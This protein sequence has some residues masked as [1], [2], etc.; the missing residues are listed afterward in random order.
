MIGSPAMLSARRSPTPSP[1]PSPVLRR[2]RSAASRVTSA[3]N[4]DSVSHTGSTGHSRFEH[5]PAD[6]PAQVAAGERV[7]R[8]MQFSFMDPIEKWRARK[9]VPFKLILQVVKVVLITIQL[10]LFATCRL[11]H[12]SYLE[13]TQ[14]SLDHLFILG[15]DVMRE[16]NAYP[17]GGGPLAVYSQRRFFETLDFA[18]NEYY[19]LDSLAVSGIG[20]TDDTVPPVQLCLHEYRNARVFPVNMSYAF[21]SH[22]RQR[23]MELRPTPNE[24]QNH[25]FSTRAFLR[26]HAFNVSFVGLTR[27]TL[28]FALNAVRLKESMPADQPDCYRLNVALVLENGDQDGRMLV[29]MD[30]K[31]HMRTCNGDLQSDAAGTSLKA[32]FT[33]ISSLVIIVCLSSFAMCLRSIYRAQLLRIE[34]ASLLR[35]HFQYHMTYEEHFR[36]LNLW[37][38]IIIINDGLIVFASL[39]H[40]QLDIDLLASPVG[41]ETW[42]LCAVVLGAGNLLVWIGMLRY[43]SF[44]KSY[45]VLILTVKSAMPSVLRFSVCA[46]ICYAGFVFCGWLVLAPYHL[47]FRTLSKTSEALF[48]LMNGDDMFATFA[49]V[50][51]R[52][53]MIYWFSKLYIYV[54][55]FFFIYVVISLMISII[56]DSYET[57]KAYYREGFPMSP[58]DEFLAVRRSDP[59]TGVYREDEDDCSLPHFC[60]C[61]RHNGSSDDRQ[62]IIDVVDDDSLTVGPPLVRTPEDQGA[63]YVV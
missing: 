1:C 60:C 23:C 63:G 14:F 37:Y 10:C 20:Y 47:K 40:I 11:A 28:S 46:M 58:L 59:E 35:E 50:W 21:D 52:S 4:A 16:V 3:L 54:F 17:P 61:V 32:F 45:N 51:P 19:D 34:A 13:N 48:S 27:T 39:V 42:N 22:L 38:V 44:F 62:P 31:A 43:F 29:K 30:L 24:I 5:I 6:D 7:R 9:K 12:V 41:V 49:Q 15:W 2:R 33:V 56:M 18:V 36:F 25:N 26:Q 53:S 8:K 55:V 57:I